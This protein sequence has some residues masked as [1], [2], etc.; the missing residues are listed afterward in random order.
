MNLVIDI[1]NT[2]F[3][4][5]FFSNNE[6]YSFGT[7]EEELFKEICRQKEKGEP[8]YAL[9]CGSGRVEDELRER[10]KT[11]IPYCLEPADKPKLPI[12]I[13]YETPDTLG[14][15]R[16]AS[17]VGANK[18]FPQQPLLVIDIGTAITYDYVGADN[19]FLGGNISPGTMLRFK[20]L[21]AFTDKLPYLEVPQTSAQQFQEYGKN[22]KE[23][24]VSGVMSGILFEVKQYM[25]RF[26]QNYVNGK[27]VIT[28]GDSP[29]ITGKLEQEFCF[30]EHLC[31]A[32]LNI[33][34]SHNYKKSS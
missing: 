9:I 1:G 31:L 30:V 25:E 12:K 8:L 3:K 32:G 4:Y 17:A 29:L 10:L 26:L 34:L 24:I 23:A 21:H 2:R 15:D 28:G 20:A 11:E 7:K 19:S 27:V 18:L 6:P 14:F 22:T 16:I 5:A 33:I 13:E